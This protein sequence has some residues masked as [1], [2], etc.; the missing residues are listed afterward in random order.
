VRYEKANTDAYITCSD[1]YVSTIIDGWK[2]IATSCCRPASVDATRRAQDL[3]DLD[4]EAVLKSWGCPALLCIARAPYSETQKLGDRL[5]AWVQ[6]LVQEQCCQLA[7]KFRKRN[8][9]LQDEQ[10]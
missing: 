3:V 5:K 8:S 10:R 4:G 2:I 1:R 7:Q 6:D 9:P